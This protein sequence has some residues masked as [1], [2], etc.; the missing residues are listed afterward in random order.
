MCVELDEFIEEL[1]EVEEEVAPNPS[2]NTRAIGDEEVQKLELRSALV[3]ALR[4]GKA[5]PPSS[6]SEA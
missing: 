6:K 2:T 1:M 4:P 5:Q 3:H